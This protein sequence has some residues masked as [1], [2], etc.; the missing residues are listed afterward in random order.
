MQRQAGRSSALPLFVACCFA[1]ADLSCRE[2]A[3]TGLAPGSSVLHLADDLARADVA[4]SGPPDSA[5]E[6]LQ[7]SFADPGPGW[8]TISLEQ[9]A[10]LAAVSLAQLDD[11]IRLGLQER[12]SNG[13]MRMGGIRTDLDELRFADWEQV[14][15]R[16]RSSDRFAG[17]T[18]AYNVEEEGA[19]PGFMRFFES[20]DEAPPMFNDGSVQ[21]YA[22]PLRPRR[23]SESPGS[24]RSLAVLFASPGPAQVDVLS[25][26]LVPR[27]ADYLED[28]GIRQ[29]A[30]GGTTR[31]TLFAHAPATLAYPVD[32]PQGGRFDFGLAVNRGEEVT[33][34]IS[35]EGEGRRRLLFEETI[36][37]PQSWHQRSVDL[38][39]QSGATVKLILESESARTGAVALWG[40]PI[41]SGDRPIDRPNVIFYVIDGGDA[42]FMSLYEYQR[43][44]TPFLEELAGE[45][46]LFTRAHSNSTWT[47]PSTASFMTSL[48]HSVLGGLRRGIHSTAVPENAVTMAER[49]RH[50]GYQT[51]SFTAN[52]NAGRM[53][54]TDRGVDL[55]RDVKTR[56][57]ST[58]SIELHQQFF[59]FRAAYPGGPYWVHFQTTDVHE[60]N[61]PE[62]PFSGRFVTPERRA[63]LNAWEETIWE[64]A[65]QDFGTTS[66]VGFYDLA[67]ERAAIDR[68]AYF[69]TRRD[70]YDETMVHPDHA[71]QALVSRLKEQGEWEK[72]LLIIGSDH[73]HPAGTFARFGRG[74]VEPQP[75]P[76]QRALFDAWATRVPLLVIWPGKIEGGRRIDAPV[77]MID[78]M[79]TI[80][81]LAG[82]EPL[83]V[84]QGRS[85]APLLRGEAM[86]P[87]PVILDEFRVDEKTGEMIGN[88]E[89]IDGRWGASLEIGP[90]TE[91]ADPKLGRHSVPAG[92][93][94]GAVHPFFP[95]VLRLLLYDLEHDPFT[96]HAVNDEHPD[97]VRH[98]TQK[99]LAQW[100]AHRALA[101]RFSEAGEVAVTPEQLEQ[102]RAL[103]YVR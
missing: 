5:R 101:Q 22:I 51:A 8:G 24:L 9:H 83:A 15:V 13:P 60:P 39:D 46:V 57:H 34:R 90:L 76:W 67:L 1:L 97:L 52:P 80:L 56:H 94:W 3:P 10:G 26:T 69:G 85:L 14:I 37:D 4:S 103:G 86:D 40:A 44:T 61:E 25:V 65:A 28:I 38:N 6:L 31:H 17:V 48:H 16:A 84:V 58:S 55:M 59:D 45:G 19:L 99:L 50:A 49:F 74:L 23:G 72:T 27:G 64:V 88:L 53:I 66:V 95:N 43:P 63:R 73:G 68:K 33:Y 70:L 89:I 42:D 75:E 18:V 47:E 11:G 2:G 98:Y 78:V 7:W 87:A 82:L 96:L 81:E 20:P 36:D 102:L 62:E 41:V 35:T 71:L 32:V 100:Q 21:A 30:R 79:P 91:G 29:V 77:S 12:H 92:G 54:G 93:R